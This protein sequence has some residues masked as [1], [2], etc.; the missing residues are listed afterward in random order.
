MAQGGCTREENAC[1][2]SILTPH[3]PEFVGTMFIVLPHRHRL[4]LA[5]GM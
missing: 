1:A 4:V 3:Q 5:A 2:T